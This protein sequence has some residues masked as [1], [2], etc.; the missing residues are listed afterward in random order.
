MLNV[1]FV[2]IVLNGKDRRIL[3]FEELKYIRTHN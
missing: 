1:K 3:K 2:K